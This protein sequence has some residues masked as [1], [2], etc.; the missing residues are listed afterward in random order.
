MGNPRA[1]GIPR[2]TSSE[3]ACMVLSTAVA[4]LAL[5]PTF[6]ANGPDP[7]GAAAQSQAPAALE[8]QVTPPIETGTLRVAL[9]ASRDTFAGGGR[10][11]A[12]GLFAPG[13]PV[14]I[15]GLAPGTYGLLVH[16]DENGNGLLDENFLGI[17][18]EPIGFANGYRPKSRPAFEG[19]MVTVRP[20]E[21]AVERVAV[22]RPLAKG[23]VGVGL[24]AVVQ[25]L[26]YRG[27]SGAR[28]Q[29]IPV[30][31]YIS[32][33]IAVLGPQVRYQV[34]RNDALTV[35]A[36]LRARFGAYAEDDADILEGMGDRDLV[37]MGGV[38]MDLQL[39]EGVTLRATYEHDLFDAVGG[40]EATVSMLR[41]FQHGPVTWAPSIGMRWTGGDLVAHDFGVE[42]R[43]ARPG[44]PAYLP[45]DALYVELGLSSRT[46]FTDN[47]Q[48]LLNVNAQFFD[49][50]VN[51]SPIV[52]DG[53]RV[54]AVLGLVWTL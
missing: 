15:E 7:R 1:W 47:L 3:T 11:A 20:G 42:T 5:A 44:R 54:S 43:F 50:E 2:G 17:P 32:D 49:D 33:R 4:L 48:F 10:P 45:G 14:V 36:T 46:Q 23:A 29:P 37:A 52:E 6:Q 30:V 9:H 18:S 16:H 34:A 38:W 26:P 21:R 13:E 12:G 35:S 31:T 41:R 24:G 53:E 25:G 8:L 19:S 22:A 51:D 27:A 39:N 28:I 40:G